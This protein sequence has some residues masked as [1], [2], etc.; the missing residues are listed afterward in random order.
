MT[1]ECA[2][3]DYPRN[4]TVLDAV[5]FNSH[6]HGVPYSGAKFVYCP[7]CGKKIPTNKQI[8]SQGSPTKVTEIMNRSNPMNGIY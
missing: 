4:M 6:A 2:C 5:I 3:E 7:W 1:E 8:V